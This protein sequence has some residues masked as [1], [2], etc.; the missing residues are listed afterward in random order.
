MYRFAANLDKSG[1]LTTSCI[2]SPSGDLLFEFH[3]RHLH[4]TSRANPE[5]VV[6]SVQVSKLDSEPRVSRGALHT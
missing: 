5:N 3:I 2:G 6:A 4:I 1:S